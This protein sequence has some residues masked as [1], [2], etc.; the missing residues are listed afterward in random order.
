[1]ARA[2]DIFRGLL[3]AAVLL[4]LLVVAVLLYSARR[5]SREQPAPQFASEQEH[6]LYGSIGT[7]GDGIPYWVWLVLPRVFPEYLPGPGGYA[8]LGFDTREGREMPIGMSRVLTG[9]VPRVGINCALCHTARVRLRP[10]DPSTIV[11]GGPGHQV[12]WERYRRFLLA[13]ASDP[14]FTSE[15]LLAEIDRNYTLPAFERMLYKWAIIPRTRKVLLELANRQPSSDRHDTGAGRA[16]AFGV[17]TL[18]VVGSPSEALRAAADITP[19]WSLGRQRDSFYWDGINTKLPEVI[20][21]WALASGSPARWLDRDASTSAAGPS[22]IGRIQSYLSGLAAPKYPLPIDQTLAQSGEATFAAECASC[23]APGAARTGTV[24]PQ[25]EIGTDTDRADAWTHAAVAS[26]NS[27]FSGKPWAF[28]SFRKT[29]GYVAPALDGVWIRAP[30]LHNGSVPSL[31][32]LLNPPDQ[33]PKRFWRG[34][35]VLD[36]N[37]VGFVSSGAEAE[38][39][40]TPYD[41]SLSGNSNGGHTFGTQLAP[42]RKR[43]LLEY[44]KGL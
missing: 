19:I 3:V 43:A 20:V 9:G 28:S 30:Y 13:C 38:R 36:A 21:A 18:P 44:M 10:N 15:T 40:G 14:R 2:A 11:P 24:I 22:A 17:G 5:L 16:A 6:F 41:T 31:A 35:D 7:E 25:R 32:D 34:Y 33:R 23:H 39:S 26:Y 8:A 4:G 37:T 42:D 1:M 27:T 29:N 12:N